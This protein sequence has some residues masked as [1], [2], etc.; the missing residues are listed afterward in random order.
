MQATIE[1][2]EGIGG[3]VKVT[4][5]YNGRAIVNVW[6]MTVDEAVREA[7]DI[8]ARMGWQLA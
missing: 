2:S 1:T 6:K 3:N 5:E 7:E 4:V 8:V